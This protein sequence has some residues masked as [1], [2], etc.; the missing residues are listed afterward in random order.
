MAKGQL[1][2]AAPFPVGLLGPEV[3][4][5]MPMGGVLPSVS[6]SDI[7]IGTNLV[8]LSAYTYTQ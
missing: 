4:L 5:G 2:Y 3:V 1:L 7:E 6:A 8:P